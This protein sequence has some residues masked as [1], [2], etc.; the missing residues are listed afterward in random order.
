VRGA[1]TPAVEA[2]RADYASDLRRP[3]A[4]HHRRPHELRD[5]F[6]DA[7]NRIAKFREVHA[8][9]DKELTLY[10]AAAQAFDAQRCRKG[11]R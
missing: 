3:R 6:D 8:A 10:R 5:E 1:T 7:R 9:A 11:A 4:V 2:A